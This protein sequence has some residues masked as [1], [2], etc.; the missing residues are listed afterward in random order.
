[1]TTKRRLF[2]HLPSMLAALALGLGVF[3]SVEGFKSNKPV[4]PTFATYTN[5]DGDTY[6]NGLD[7]TLFGNSFLTK[8]RELN[9]SKRQSTVGY[10]SMGT[11][12][13]GQFKYTDYDTNYV[14]YDSNGQP[15]GTRIS[16][17]YTFT[18]ATDWNREHVWPNS[19]GGGS[20][21]DAGTPYPDADIHMPRPTISSENS[22]RGNSFF[23]EGMNSTSAGWDPSTAGYSANSRGEAARITFYCTLVN[24]K[25]ILAPNN[26]TPSG[27]DPVTGQSYG[28]GHTM[29]NLETLIK[30]NINYPV[31]QREINRNEGAE[32]LQGNRNAFVDHPEYACKIWGNVNSTI[33]NMC[34]TAGHEVPVGVDISKSTDS[35]TVGD[36][37]TISA[38]STNS[39][40]ITWT[41]S[42]A[43]V[44]GISSGTANSGASI[45]L[46]ALSAGSATITAKATIGGSQYSATCSVTVSASGGQGQTETYTRLTS[47]SNIDESANY[48]LGVDGTGFHYAGTSSWG[49]TALPASQT[50]L[51]YRLTKGTNNSSFTAKTSINNTN[52]YLTVP[53]SNTFTM[54]TSSTSIKLGTTTSDS[55]GNPNYAVANVN[56][57]G[58]H[59]RINGTSGLRSYEG[60]TGTMAYFYKVN[61]QGSQTPTLSSITISGYTSSFIEGDT[62]SFGGTVTAHYSDNSSADVT[63]QA[64]FSGYD[65]TSIGNQTITVSY[66]GKTTTYSITVSKGTL[67]SIA[68]SGCTTTYSKGA[69]FSFDGICTAT[70][71]NGYQK[72][73]TPSSVSSPDMSA[74]GSKTITVSY[75]YNG[76]TKTTSYTITVTSNRTVIESSY[77]TIGTITYTT[78]V[79]VISVNTLNTSSSGGYSAID[80]QYHAWRLGASSKTGTLTVNSNTSNIKK[81]VVNAK[82]YSNDSGTS[83]TIG[84]T[85][86]T[87]T[88]NYADYLKEYDSPTNSVAISSVTSGKRVL[89]ASITVYSYS[90]QNISNTEDCIGIETFIDSNM[91]MDYTQNLGYCKDN[92]HHYYS[93]AKTAFNNLNAHQRSLFVSNSAYANEWA[94]LSAWASANGESLNSSNQLGQKVTLSIVTELAGQNN[95]TIVLVI[96][97]IGGIASIGVCFY[98]N[99]KR[100]DE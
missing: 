36:T 58:R 27:T 42:N 97:T 52:Y 19:H 24:S 57:T 77:S 88:N 35:L 31:S 33:R 67:S 99:K 1:M 41:T 61:S 55:N 59:L 11:D 83:F 29:G 70:F 51:Y 86:K 62:F 47:I 18:S 25:L 76:V 38:T 78:D 49:N 30:W 73:V 80:T 63:N 89:I 64:S 100:T 66:G 53:T 48:V 7:T 56:T 46:T 43:S 22:D 75:T 6:Y 37:T 60:T 84:G 40:T 81:I 85:S 50:P 87:L 28:S 69:V 96:L 54:S 39:S 5:G 45:T 71:G 98:I 94:R 90:S 15:Y 74:A 20:K 32:Y 72:N 23:V 92:A 44:V 93:T 17:F 3:V 34:T 95:I 65:L 9:L 12:P 16:S 10:S 14:Q 2:K 68:V 21:G 79:E 13:S 4:V 8:L 26:T 82:Y 91:H